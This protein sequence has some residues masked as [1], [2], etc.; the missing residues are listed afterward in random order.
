MG[1]NPK[2]WTRFKV[3][4]P[5]LD[6]GVGFLRSERAVRCLEATGLAS[7]ESMKLLRAMSSVSTLREV[8]FQDC[9]VNLVEPSLLSMALS[10]HV[11]VNLENAA[12]TEQQLCAL[13]S[14][15]ALMAV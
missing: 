3:S 2:F 15:M 12:L 13:C 9:L 8:R 14:L 7:E 5:S 1:S 11:K 6:A 4:L 10:N